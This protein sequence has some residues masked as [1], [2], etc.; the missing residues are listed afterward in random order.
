MT[1][2]ILITLFVAWFFGTMFL[3]YKG[4]RLY[5]KH[6][7]PMIPSEPPLLRLPWW[8]W[9]YMTRAFVLEAFL[10][11]L[12]SLAFFAICLAIAWLVI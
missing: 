10:N 9:K 11:F 12:Q 4:I 5:H 2:A 8:N 7:V 3:L 6:G 1:L